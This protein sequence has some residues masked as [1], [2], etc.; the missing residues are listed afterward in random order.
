M[1]A[2][3]IG[4]SAPAG[5][6]PYGGEGLVSRHGGIEAEAGAART[7]TVVGVLALCGTAVSLQ[8]TLVV[9]LL[10]EFPRMLHTA[11]DNASWLVTATLVAGAVAIPTLSRLADMFGKKRM[12]LVAI[13]VMVA[14]SALGAVSSSL[15]LLIAARALQGVGIALIPIGIAIMRDELPPARLPLGVAVLSATLAIGAGAGLPLVGL[16]VEHL[17]WHWLFWITGATGAVMCAAVAMV[18]PESP[19]R[20][21]GSFD[22]TGALLLSAAITGFMIAVSKGAHWGW[23][24]WPTLSLAL[25][26]I[27]LLAVWLPL[28][29]HSSSPLVDVRVSSRPAVLLVNIASVLTGFAMYANVLV[30]AQIL[31]QPTTTGYGLGLDIFH[32]GLW[33]APNALVF[34]AMAPVAASIIRRVGPQAALLA[35]AFGMSA[36][37]VLR[38]FVSHE[39]WQIELGSVLVSVGT[40]LT[41]AAMPSL[42][43]RAVPTTETASANGLNTVL[44][45]VGTSTSS[46]ALAAITTAMVIHVGEHVYPSF[47]GFAAV[48]WIAAAASLVAGVLV[49]PLLRMPDETAESPDRDTAIPEPAAVRA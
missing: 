22:Y 41:F 5:E 16:V 33:L 14:G 2:V 11:P 24:S 9:P 19:V 38:A 15:P 30:T 36:S 1:P 43:M 17:D 28:E 40:S 42:I 20:S 21:P 34:G 4:V 47:G 37:Y 7:A 45:S 44:R 39:L 25:S 8:Q 29:L 13:A 26:G 32:A 27:A 23:L 12:M 46:A 3:H 18:V 6:D 48:F 31:Q 10:P 35:G 49:L